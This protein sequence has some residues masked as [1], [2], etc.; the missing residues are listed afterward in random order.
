M[1]EFHV[2]ADTSLFGNS[3]SCGGPRRL[4]PPYELTGT[5]GYI[6]DRIVLLFALQQKAQDVG[7]IIMAEVSAVE[8]PQRGVIDDCDADTRRADLLEAQHMPGD[9]AQVLFVDVEQRLFVGN[10]DFVHAGGGRLQAAGFRLQE[11]EQYAR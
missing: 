11:I 9:A 7:V 1:N 8:D 4:G 2:T 10:R 5:D 3:P 6:R